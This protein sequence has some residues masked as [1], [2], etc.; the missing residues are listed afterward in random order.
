MKKQF[1]NRILSLVL[2]LVMMVGLLPTISFTASAAA[3]E[4]FQGFDTYGITITS[5]YFAFPNASNGSVWTIYSGDQVYN[6][7]T[8]E[9][10]IE[11]E[12]VNGKVTACFIFSWKDYLN[13]EKIPGKLELDCS[14]DK[15][16]AYGKTSPKITFDDGSILYINMVKNAKSHNMTKT[17]NGDNTHTSTCSFCKET[18]KE[19]CSGASGVNC[20]NSGTCTA[21]KGQYKNPSVHTW[22]YSASGNAVT[23]SCPCGKAGSYKA[24]LQPNTTSYTYTGDPFTNAAS[25]TYPIGWPGEKP[26]PAAGDYSNNTNVGT[27]TVTTTVEGKELTTTFKI[28]PA[29]I[30]DATVALNPTSGDYNGTEQKPDISVIYEG[31]LLTEN[32][33]YTFLWDKTGFI[34]ADAYTVTVT[35]KGNFEGTKRWKFTINAANLTDVKVEQIGT[36]T[37]DGGNALTPTVSANAVA[38][39]NQPITFTYST[40]QNGNYGSLPSFTKA[41][42]YTGVCSKSQ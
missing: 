35:G 26:Q 29:D 25:I 36:L 42:T 1:T 32:T 10:Y 11:G 8:L 33:D 3:A 31:L 7:A 9:L 18:S 39:N 15:T 21:C 23:A 37:Y 28:D 19:N 17:S 27:A 34:N 6:G 38:V 13:G 12:P 24:T 2:A 14:C 40:E 16:Y 20:T 41:G 4:L 30:A 5:V 22:T